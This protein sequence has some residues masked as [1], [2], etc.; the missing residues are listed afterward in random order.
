MSG[1]GAQPHG[2]SAHGAGQTSSAA[3]AIVKASTTPTSVAQDLIA[4]IDDARQCRAD[5]GLNAHRVFLVR[6][7]Y[8]GT[9][10]GTGTPTVTASEILPPPKQVD[11]R[12]KGRLRPS[13][14]D[15]EDHVLL[16]GITL[17]LAE[18][19]LFSPSDVGDQDLFLYRIDGALGSHGIR[20]RFYVPAD[21]PEINVGGKDGDRESF[22][23]SVNLRRVQDPEEA[24]P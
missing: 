5:L 12:L 9:R 11:T 14:L 3:T 6:I 17:T 10:H 22:S 15:E 1:H 24:M 16:T 8:D 19:D 4:C 13:G 21:P 18:T 20:S 23:W 7:T 2:G